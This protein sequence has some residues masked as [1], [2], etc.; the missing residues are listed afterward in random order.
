MRTSS[1]VSPTLYIPTV[2]YYPD[3]DDDGEIESISSTCTCALNCELPPMYVYPRDE[4]NTDS[5]NASYNG[6][7]SSS[8]S[9]SNSNISKRLVGGKYL[10]KKRCRPPFDT[11]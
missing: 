5:N 4:S 6:S 3:D 9:V 7:S 1:L 2:P 11:C 8:T 10:H